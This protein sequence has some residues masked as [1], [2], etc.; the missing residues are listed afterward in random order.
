MSELFGQESSPEGDA[1]DV[2]PEPAGAHAAE[3]AVEMTGHPRVDGVLASL[4]QVAD[5]PGADQVAVYESAHEALRA[6]L[7]DAG[8]NH[9]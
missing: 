5:L 4:D 2:A 8:S 1:P 9:P 6:A 7:T 3:P